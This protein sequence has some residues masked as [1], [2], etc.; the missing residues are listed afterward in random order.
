MAE[1]PLS[2]RLAFKTHKLQPGEAIERTWVAGVPWS[3]GDSFRG[4]LSK[5]G[6]NLVLTDRRLLFEPLGAPRVGGGLRGLELL[7]LEGKK[8]FEFSDIAAVEPFS[9]RGPPRLK[10][11]LG[12]GEEVVLA[13]MKGRAA[14]M[15]SKDTAARDEAV[16]AISAA[17]TPG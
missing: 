6:G 16:A 4:R 8:A 13:V 15:W 12:G 1:R 17:I 9:K 5:F 7:F 14:T 11:T 2:H 10:L 3:Q